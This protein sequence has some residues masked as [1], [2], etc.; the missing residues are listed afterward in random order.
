MVFFFMPLCFRGIPG[1][2]ST[3]I[4]VSIRVSLSTCI[5]RGTRAYTAV[6]TCG[7]R[8]LSADPG[9]ERAIPGT[10][11]SCI[12]LLSKRFR[13][14]SSLLLSPLLVFILPLPVGAHS[15]RLHSPVSFYILPGR[16]RVGH[17]SFF[18]TKT[19]PPPTS[20]KRFFACFFLWLVSPFPRL[21][22][23]R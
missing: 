13:S 16:N 18:F 6:Y 22:S 3:F 23:F 10:C 1:R 12:G 20:I 11:S 7:Y 9:G 17:P 8:C 2:K 14:V 21:F 4:H 19:R 15:R 5:W